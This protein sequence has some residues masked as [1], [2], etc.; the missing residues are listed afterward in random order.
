MNESVINNVSYNSNI[1]YGVNARS[2]PHMK[3]F[4][5]SKHANKN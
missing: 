2:K 5:S 3:R 4:N 1:F